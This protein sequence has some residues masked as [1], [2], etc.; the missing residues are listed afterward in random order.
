MDKWDVGCQGIA[1]PKAG[2]GFSAAAIAVSQVSV[3]VANHV[4]D[5]PELAAAVK[6]LAV[7]DAS[8]EGLTDAWKAWIQA[9]GAPPRGQ[10][11]DTSCSCV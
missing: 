7:A 11:R 8:K 9:G 5:L 4:E 6:L 2:A 10:L 3:S 1:A